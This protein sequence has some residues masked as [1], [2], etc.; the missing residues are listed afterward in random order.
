MGVVKGVPEGVVKGVPVGVVKRTLSLPV[1]PWELGS[2]IFLYF[3]I[4]GTWEDSADLYY[5]AE[6]TGQHTKTFNI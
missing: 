2:G 3:V 5:W 4:S 6:R 1:D